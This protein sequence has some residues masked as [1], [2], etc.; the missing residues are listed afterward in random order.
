[1]FLFDRK[2]LKNLDGVL[3]LSVV[4]LGVLGCLAV[5][6]ATHDNPYLSGYGNKQVVWFVLGLGVMS[7]T[8]FVD[9][10]F[11]E[12]VNRWIYGINLALLSAV[13]VPGLGYEA[14]GAQRWV[15]LGY[16]QLQPSELSKPAIIITLAVLLLEHQDKIREFSTVI[17]S[18]L[19]VL[20]CMFLV[21]IQPDL[22][23]ALVIVA[24]WLGML[25][26]S[27]ARLRHLAAIMVGGGLL[28]SLAWHLNLVRPY[29]K[30]RLAAF[31]HPD[32]SPLDAGYHVIQS[33]IAI[34]SGQLWGKGLFHGTQNKLNFIPEQHT[35]FIYTIVGEEGGFVGSTMVLA[36]YLV[37]LLRGIQIV[38]EN[39]NPLGSLMGSGIL[40]LLAFHVVVNIGM[41]MRVMPIAGVPLP[42][43]SYGGSSMLS[44]ML[45][46]GLLLGIGTRRQKLTF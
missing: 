17:K 24:L 42:F 40:S 3:L 46:I 28:F 11:F 34:G 14:G 13:L 5:R 25:F 30:D 35:D 9:W 20:P 32:L 21:L 15:N 36:L 4:A 22:G 45:L 23:T 10:Q 18:L 31:L 7:L 6:S 37:L 26:I 1:M 19:H 41:T 29:Q 27:G 38:S 44:S 16:F 12:R 33:Q 39:E 2:T 43:L 8:L